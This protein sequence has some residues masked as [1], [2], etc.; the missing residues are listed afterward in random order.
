M[1]Y[2]CARWDFATGIFGVDMSWQMLFVCA[3]V[4]LKKSHGEGE[5]STVPIFFVITSLV[6][7]IVMPLAIIY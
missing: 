3:C 6:Q 5:M 1:T 2:V 4:S 7:H